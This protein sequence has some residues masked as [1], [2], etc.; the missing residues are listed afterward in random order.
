MSNYLTRRLEADP[1]ITIHYN[2]QVTTL[3][4]EDHLEGV[5]FDGPEAHTTWRRGPCS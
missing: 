2:T 5:T 4:G 1:G 3:K